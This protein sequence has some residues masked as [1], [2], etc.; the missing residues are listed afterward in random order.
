MS[1][2]V[3]NLR[4]LPVALCGLLT[5]AWTLSLFASL[6]FSFHPPGQDHQAAIVN[7]SMLY[8]VIAMDDGVR[9]VNPQFRFRWRKEDLELFGD[10]EFVVGT[11]NHLGVGSW[12]LV[13]PIPFL[14]TILAILALAPLVRL[15]LWSCFAWTALIAL[16][17]AY[18]LTMR[19]DI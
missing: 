7:G 3:A 5:A 13:F 6:S 11:E 12:Y 8:I 18:Y 15:P 1:C 10:F 19:N 14:L 9:D 17:L 16:E 2:L 4:Y